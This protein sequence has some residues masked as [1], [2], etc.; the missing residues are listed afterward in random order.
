LRQSHMGHES[1]CPELRCAQEPIRPVSV[2][3]V[4][5]R[6]DGALIAS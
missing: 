5:S 3:R 1:R 2:E 4:F 6:R